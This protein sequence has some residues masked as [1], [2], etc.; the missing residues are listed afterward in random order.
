MMEEV[1]MK[2]LTLAEFL[3]LVE[4]KDKRFV[5]IITHACYYIEQGRIY[6]F[7][8]HQNSK[9]IEKVTDYSAAE[10]TLS[11]LLEEMKQSVLNQMRYDWFTDVC[12]EQL[13]ERLK[14]MPST[15]EVLFF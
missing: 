1:K 2:T 9:M 11:D 8:Q 14:Q 4:A 6:R 7:Q 5:A 15:I 12:K 13:S 10:L 3:A